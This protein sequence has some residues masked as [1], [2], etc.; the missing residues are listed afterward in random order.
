[1]SPSLLRCH[2]FSYFSIFSIFIIFFYILIC[3]SIFLLFFLY[4]FLYF[5]IFVLF[6]SIIC[7]IFSYVL[8]VSIFFPE[9]VY[10]FLY[11]SVLFPYNYKGTY[12]L[13][14][15]VSPSL[16][17]CHNFSF[18]FYNS[19]FL[20]TRCVLLFEDVFGRFGEG[21]RDIVGGVLDRL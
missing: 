10:A 15:W 11:F 18:N 20:K 7:I 1:M 16:L 3:F 2:N 12:E 14:V 17:R 9:F 13:I 6:V 5:F 4:W 19:P 8:Y 21:V